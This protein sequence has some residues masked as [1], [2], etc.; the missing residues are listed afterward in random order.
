MF[1]FPV[2]TLFL[3]IS[4]QYIQTINRVQGVSKKHGNLE[5]RL[6][7]LIFMKCQKVYKTS[8]IWHCKLLDISH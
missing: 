3:L 5:G 4:Q 6:Q 8:F 7:L 1:E 2:Y